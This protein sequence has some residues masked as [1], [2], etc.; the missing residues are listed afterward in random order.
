MKNSTNLTQL[1]LNTG[2]ST[3]T[4]TWVFCPKLRYLLE[5][6]L[7]KQGSSI[8]GHKGWYTKI[9]QGNEYAYF[10]VC[11]EKHKEVST[12]YLA[13]TSKGAQ[14]IWNLLTVT[15][16]VVDIRFDHGMPDMPA[17]T[18]WLT[19]YVSTTIATCPV[20]RSWIEDF[21]QCLARAIISREMAR[22]K[23]RTHEQ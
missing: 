18:P 12:T 4:Q 2:E 17:S 21:T 6:M 20:D 1:I 19:T 8:P 3:I 7:I 23:V 11:D 16:I 15:L 9:R 5:P 22:E 13:W 14:I 10:V